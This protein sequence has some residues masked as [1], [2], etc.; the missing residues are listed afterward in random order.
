M[1]TPENQ[2]NFELIIGVCVL[3]FFI[4]FFMVSIISHQRKKAALDFNRLKADLLLLEKE[5]SRI[6]FDLHDALGPALS[7][8]KQKMEARGVKDLSA[9]I[10]GLMM[11]LRTISQNMLPRTLEREGLCEAVEE[12]AE[13]SGLR[14]KFKPVRNL[15]LPLD[16][17]LHL[18]RLLQEI[19]HNTAKH[20]A[21][22][23]L[24]LSIIKKGNRLQITAADNGKGFD[25]SQVA[26][27]SAGLGLRNIVSRADMI[28]ATVELETA[29]GK[30]TRYKI[31]CAV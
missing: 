18:Y 16:T 19:L 10:D 28:G 5:R 27:A 31:N 3:L 2:L 7:V 25:R 13:Q 22:T 21:A 11:Q 4:T 26:G 23:E 24:E 9:E 8:C 15:V 6:A 29:P 20:A 1:P 12:L 30:G 17:S 14:Y